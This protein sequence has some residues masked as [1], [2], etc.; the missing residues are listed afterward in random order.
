MY[1]TYP[2]DRYN[3]DNFN[4]TIAGSEQGLDNAG[5]EPHRAGDGG[6]SEPDC[7]VWQH[8]I[9]TQ[10]EMY[11][12]DNVLGMVSFIFLTS[13]SWCWKT[14]DRVKRK[15]RTFTKMHLRYITF[16]MLTSMCIKA[17]NII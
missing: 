9:S 17:V 14:S 15:R 5:A 16:T 13:V 2:L 4:I 7:Q 12:V 8:K 11:Y 1:Y 6:H 10:T 3:Y